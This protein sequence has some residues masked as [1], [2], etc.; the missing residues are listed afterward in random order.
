MGRGSG[1]RPLLPKG[2]MEARRKGRRRPSLILQGGSRVRPCS[3]AEWDLGG[4]RDGQHTDSLFILE[5][6]GSRPPA[7]VG[8]WR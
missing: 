1:G 3:Q 2:S 5:G 4:D 6:E 7:S 8:Y